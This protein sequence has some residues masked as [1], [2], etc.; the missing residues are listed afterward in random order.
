MHGSQ[1]G[2]G[3]YV[4]HFVT[5]RLG[6][7]RLA[8]CVDNSLTPELSNVLCVRLAGS[9]KFDSSLLYFIDVVAYTSIRDNVQ[10]HVLTLACM[11]PSPRE[12]SCS[13]R[14][15]ARCACLYPTYCVCCVRVCFLCL[16]GVPF[17]M[18]V[19]I[20]SYTRIVQAYPLQPFG[21]Q[22]LFKAG[23]NFA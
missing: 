14:G 6:V 7:V 9:E 15:A 1:R 23:M 2:P 18:A 19:R 17:M 13:G 5:R 20:L 11:I 3:L 21:V 4:F 22:L 8:F 16:C 12:F 10:L